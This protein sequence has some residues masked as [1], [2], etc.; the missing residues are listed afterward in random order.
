MRRFLD[1]LEVWQK[2]QRT[3]QCQNFSAVNEGWG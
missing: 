3:A 2:T 1:G